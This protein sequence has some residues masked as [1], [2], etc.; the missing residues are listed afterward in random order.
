MLERGFRIERIGLEAGPLSH[1]LCEG[2]ARTG[3]PMICVQTRHTKAFLRAQINA[4]DRNDAP[5]IDQMLRD[6]LY[7]P[8]HVNTL[9]SQKRRDSLRAR[10]LLQ[11]GAIACRYAATA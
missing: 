1:W 10:K 5:G 6:S 2:L 11:V 3:P 8:V 7:R 4:S 9:T